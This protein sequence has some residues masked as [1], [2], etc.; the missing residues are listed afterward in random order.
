MSI[1][2]RWK[3][4]NS[5]FGMCVCVCVCVCVCAFVH[6]AQQNAHNLRPAR[7]HTYKHTH[8]HKHTPPQEEPDN[9]E[10]D[11]IDPP[12]PR[13]FEP[14]RS[15]MLLLHKKEWWATVLAGAQAQQRA[16]A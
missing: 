15:D 8:T 14:S 3:T 13:V 10:E 2:P 7:T 6:F 12:A 5:R 4:G 1:C 9:P 11:I 16:G